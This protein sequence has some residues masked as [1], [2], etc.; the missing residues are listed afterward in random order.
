MKYFITVKRGMNVLLNKVMI[1]AKDRNDAKEIAQ[2]LYSTK[3]HENQ[4]SYGLFNSANYVSIFNEKGEKLCGTLIS[5]L[6]RLND[7]EDR[8]TTE[9][10]NFYSL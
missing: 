3:L 1:E 6:H 4:K 9:V 2:D 5:C 10:F 8:E 7:W